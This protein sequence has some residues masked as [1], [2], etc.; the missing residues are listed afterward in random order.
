MSQPSDSSEILEQD[1]TWEYLKIA[2]DLES[3]ADAVLAALQSGQSIADAEQAGVESY[4]ANHIPDHGPDAPK[5]P[6]KGHTPPTGE[7]IMG[8]ALAKLVSKER[9]RF[10]IEFHWLRY[11]VNTLA[12]QDRDELRQK[13]ERRL[14]NWN[15]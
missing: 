12:H 6:V 13:I 14:S 2:Y 11:P 8:L 1:N 7:M 15:S 9:R 5:V 3:A 10:E 4:R